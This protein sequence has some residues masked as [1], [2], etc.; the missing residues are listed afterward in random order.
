MN[1]TAHAE[2]VAF[3]AIE[4]YFDVSLFLLVVTGL[5]AMISTGK[6]DPVSTALPLIALLWKGIRVFRRQAPELSQRTATSLVLAYLLFF[7]L[8]LWFLSRSLASDAPNPTL[9]AGLLAAIHLLIF[10]TLV[11]LLSARSHRDQLFLA[12]LSFAC[13]LASAIL[14][15]GPGFLMI[16]AI[17]LHWRFPH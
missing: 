6:L 14:T 8:D 3:P 10:A 12:M 7:P 13:M 1:S 11:R 9:Y 15:V 4:R 2:A 5:V 16:L 17:F